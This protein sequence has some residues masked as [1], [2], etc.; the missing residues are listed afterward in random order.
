MIVIARHRLAAIALVAAGA[1]T[2]GACGGGDTPAAVVNG[3]ET[4]IADVQ[5][6][7]R[8]ANEIAARNG[9][10]P[11]SPSQVLGTLMYSSEVIAFA[12]ENGIAVPTTD[13]VRSEVGKVVDVGD[14]AI[15]YYRTMIA[16]QGLN[17]EQGAKLGE[18]L[19]STSVTLNPR[20]GRVNDQHMLE[21]WGAD[22]IKPV[23]TADP[24]AADPGAPAPAPDAPA[25]TP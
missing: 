8:A 14:G 21:A 10:Q 25:P 4:T 1:L 24:N 16:A 18:R 2:L 9:Q 19:Q 7:T 12:E 13:W 23:E 3:H 6:A 15:T 22:W 11:T 5:D 17:Q 20:Y